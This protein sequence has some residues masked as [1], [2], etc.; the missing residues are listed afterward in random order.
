MCDRQLTY[1]PARTRSGNAEGAHQS[2]GFGPEID[3][4][5]YGSHDSG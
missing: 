1:Q 3:G 4:E 2:N 5:R